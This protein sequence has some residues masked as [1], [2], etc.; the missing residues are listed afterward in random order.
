VT[1]GRGGAV[2]IVQRFGAA[3]NVN[4]H[5]H[6][7]VLDGVFAEDSTGGL[8]FHPAPPPADDEMEQVLG[9]IE[10]RV[11]RLLARRG[12]D[13]DPSVGADRWADEEPVL[14]GLTGASV[15]GRIAF[16]ARAGAEVRRRG[17]SAER[18]A[19]ASSAPG[20]C[21]ARGHG[22]DLHAGVDVPGRDRAR[23]ERICRYALRPPVADER[24][25]LTS[26]GQV[27]LDLR[28]RW[29]DGTTHLVFDPLE[30]LERLAALTPRPRINLVLYYGVLGAHAAWRGRLRG[31][32]AQATAR[33]A[34]TGD[35]RHSAGAAE[36]SVPAAASPRHGSNLRWAQ[37]MQ[38]SFGYDVLA[39]PRCGGRLRL[40]ALI[41]DPAVIQ[42]ILR[43][44]GLPS[45]V[46]AA[47][48]V[49][50]P[51]LPFPSSHHHLLDEDIA[52]S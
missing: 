47:R 30:L 48:S 4:V 20:A 16:G 2:V 34:G 5:G 10:R 17:A 33:D 11:R 45:D 49:R 38:R 23:L 1:D 8:R 41:E 44:L 19:L 36:S 35:D 29:S 46:P 27:L 21:H 42:R 25:H 3:L 14:A 13:D 39:C 15:Q 24:I 40:I 51:P 43:H 37:L 7:L 6:A 18:G 12:K 52:T 26:T 32:P 28:H 50:A 31:C 22:F 9:T